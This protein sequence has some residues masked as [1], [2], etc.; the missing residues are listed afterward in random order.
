MTSL[1]S[2][3]LIRFAIALLIVLAVAILS[4]LARAAPVDIEVQF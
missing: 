3:R 4:R 1:R 2:S